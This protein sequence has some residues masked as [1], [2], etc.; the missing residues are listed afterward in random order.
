MKITM[1]MMMTSDN[2]DDDDE[3]RFIDACYSAQQIEGMC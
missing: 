3:P 1:M 2:D